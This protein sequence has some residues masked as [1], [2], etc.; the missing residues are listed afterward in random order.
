MPLNRGKTSERPPYDGCGCA[1]LIVIAI[2]VIAFL[3]SC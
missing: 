1:V 3:K 2:V